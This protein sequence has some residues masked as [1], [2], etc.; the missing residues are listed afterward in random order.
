MKISFIVLYSK[1]LLAEKV[2]AP[3]AGLMARA[4]K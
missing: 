3:R 2:V 4:N 1:R